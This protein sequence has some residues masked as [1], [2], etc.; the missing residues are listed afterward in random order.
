MNENT[1]E[2]PIISIT[3]GE[4]VNFLGQKPSLEIDK[5]DF[6]IEDLNVEEVLERVS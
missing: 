2:I 4:K 6:R 1:G 3:I 5:I